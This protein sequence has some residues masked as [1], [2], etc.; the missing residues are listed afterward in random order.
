MLLRL[1]HCRISVAAL[2]EQFVAPF[3]T[4]GNRGLG[5][6]I[7]RD[8]R[9]EAVAHRFAV[10]AI[11]NLLEQRYALVADLAHRGTHLDVVLLPN[12]TV[13]VVGRPQP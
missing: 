4:H 5:F 7:E 6:R 2:P 10:G 1:R 3:G 13:E 8:H 12:L 9:R 11:D